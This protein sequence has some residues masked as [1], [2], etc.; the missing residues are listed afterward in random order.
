MGS[1][2]RFANLV[3]MGQGANL[4]RPV[5]KKLAVQE[6]EGLRVCGAECS[7]PRALVASGAVLTSV[8]EPAILSSVA[9]CATLTH[10]EEREKKVC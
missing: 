5:P 7:H 3:L 10:P 6:G 4:R 8:S 1:Y 9:H 2:L